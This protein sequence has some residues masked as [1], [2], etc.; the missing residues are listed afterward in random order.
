MRPGTLLEGRAQAPGSSSSAEPWMAPAFKLKVLML[1]K[2]QWD[3]RHGPPPAPH[4]EHSQC[5]CHWPAQPLARALQD[6]ISPC[7]AGDL[8]QQRA[9]GLLPHV[10]V[11]HIPMVDPQH[12]VVGKQQAEQPF[13]TIKAHQFSSY[14]AELGRPMRA[15]LMDGAPFTVVGKHPA[16]RRWCVQLQRVVNPSS[17]QRVSIP[18]HSRTNL[19]CHQPLSW[20]TATVC[21]LEGAH[22]DKAW[23]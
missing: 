17:C 5:T 10:C 2:L 12:L 1:A 21:M 4:S 11:T 16:V 3:T 7:V 18:A 9:P 8:L 6:M 13:H 19:D 14:L 22:V 23:L 15:F 20:Q